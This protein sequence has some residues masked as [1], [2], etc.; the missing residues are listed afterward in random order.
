[1]DIVSVT[2]YLLAV[3]FVRQ[4]RQ[5]RQSRWW[6]SALAV[7]LTSEMTKSDERDSHELAVTCAYCVSGRV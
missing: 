5:C 7:I 1:M 3:L 4:L 6:P 2:G